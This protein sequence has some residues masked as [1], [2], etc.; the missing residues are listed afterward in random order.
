MNG[1]LHGNAAPTG[2]RGSAPTR[3]TAA[4]K[5]PGS[6]ARCDLKGPQPLD[7]RR[8]RNPSRR[9]GG[10]RHRVGEMAVPAT[11]TTCERAHGAYRTAWPEYGG[12]LKDPFVKR[13]AAESPLASHAVTRSEFEHEADR[14][15][16]PEPPV[17]LGV[18]RRR[19]T[20]L[21]EGYRVIDAARI[22]AVES[23]HDLHE[24]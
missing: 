24:P 22:G 20:E 16:P 2:R 14:R 17:D 8:R 5:R 11:A 13:F 15:H 6:D 7:G 23:I 4:P 18:E 19:P 12:S 9:S 10:L 21:V 3:S 1:S